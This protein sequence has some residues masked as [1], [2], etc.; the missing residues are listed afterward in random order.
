[1]AATDTPLTDAQ[2]LVAARMLIGMASD[3][4]QRGEHM[5]LVPARTARRLGD[6]LLD[7]LNRRRP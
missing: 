5:V 1:M 2:L 7:A 4:E 6:A 3:A